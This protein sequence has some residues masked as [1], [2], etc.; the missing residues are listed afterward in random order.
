MDG[1]RERDCWVGARGVVRVAGRCVRLLGV[2][3]EF[4]QVTRMFMYY[5]FSVFSVFLMFRLNC[6][7]LDNS[8]C[9]CRFVN[10]TSS[11]YSIQNNTVEL[12]GQGKFRN[13][14]NSAALAGMDEVPIRTLF[15]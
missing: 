3:G 6:F 11:M 9:T 8:S 15:H 2:F 5:S 1:E 4:F 10:R 13:S 7:V 12:T 14:L